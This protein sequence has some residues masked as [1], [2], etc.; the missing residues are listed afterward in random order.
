MEKLERK[1]VKEVR[2]DSCTSKYLV[3]EELQKKKLRGRARKRA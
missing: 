2:V 1:Y 3:S